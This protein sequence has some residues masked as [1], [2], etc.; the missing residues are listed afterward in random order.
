MRKLISI[1]LQTILL[2]LANAA[3]D[4]TQPFHVEQFFERS[5]S[6]PMTG[7]HLIRTHVFAFV[8]DGV[9]LMLAVYV[10]I[11]LIEAIRKRVLSAAID[12]TIA[13]LLATIFG[14]AAGYGFGYDAFTNLHRL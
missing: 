5:S 13:L 14:F 9:L 7:G 2:I 11:L 10:A 6:V 3:G 12:S 8:W 1:G 4:L